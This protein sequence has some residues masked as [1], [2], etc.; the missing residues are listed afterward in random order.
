MLPQP[1]AALLRVA[2]QR[3]VVADNA[4]AACAQV[5]PLAEALRAPVAFQQA[6]ADA[7][8]RGLIHDPICLPP[9]SL[10]CHWRL[11]LTP[12]GLAAA[13]ALSAGA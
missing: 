5:A 3:R 8:A 12:A 7:L 9:G 10:H 6:V 4:E 13:L 11:D 1:V 2:L